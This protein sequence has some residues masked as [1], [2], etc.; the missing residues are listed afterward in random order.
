MNTIELTT[1][2]SSVK[3]EIYIRQT[4]ENYEITDMESELV[5]NVVVESEDDDVIHVSLK[6][7]QSA[8]FR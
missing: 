8:L 7:S 6:H 1:I 3:A 4:E 2:S 5:D